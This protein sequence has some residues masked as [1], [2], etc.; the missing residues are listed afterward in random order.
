MVVAGMDDAGPGALEWIG[1][2]DGQ[3]AARARRERRRRSLAV[4]ACAALALRLL[5]AH[6]RLLLRLDE[7]EARLRAAGID[8]PEADGSSSRSRRWPASP[9]RPSRCRRSTGRP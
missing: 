5:R 8:L 1:D 6:G 9:R 3:R 7:L 2:L 4:V